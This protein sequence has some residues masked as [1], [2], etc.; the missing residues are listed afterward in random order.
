MRDLVVISGTFVVD[1]DLGQHSSYLDRLRFAEALGAAIALRSVVE[2]ECSCKD[3]LV[4]LREQVADHIQD[5]ACEPDF[6]VASEQD[7]YDT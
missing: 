1:V 6:V 7:L 3:L 4:E 2:W 5:G